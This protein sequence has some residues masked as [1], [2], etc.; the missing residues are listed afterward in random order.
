LWGSRRDNDIDLEPDEFGRDLAESFP[1]AI[2]DRDGAILDPA[3]F[4]QALH[5]ALTHSLLAERVLWPKNPIVGSFGRC[6][7]RRPRA[8]MRPP[9]RRAA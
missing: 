1:P 6:C 4:A 7:R 3:E 8:A 2:V 9:R 5:K